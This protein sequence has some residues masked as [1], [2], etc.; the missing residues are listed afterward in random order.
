M[1]QPNPLPRSTPE[2]SASSQGSSCDAPTQPNK[3]V[4]YRRA[5]CI[6][7][8][9][10]V[11]Q[12]DRRGVQHRRVDLWQDPAAAARVR[13]AANGNETVPTVGIGP[14]MLVNPDV[15]AVLAAA[16]EHAPQAVPAGYQS[17][18][19]GRIGRWLFAKLSGPPAP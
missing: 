2:V 5:G 9:V 19:R 15:H 14:V 17:P 8:S 1:T 3:I 13:S 16:A 10:L 12:P 4:V 6:V 7:C 18:Q 11:R